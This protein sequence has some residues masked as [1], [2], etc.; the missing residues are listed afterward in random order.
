[1][2]PSDPVIR[3]T[4]SDVKNSLSAYLRKVRAGETVLIMDRKTPIASLVP[5]VQSLDNDTEAERL[6]R[7]VAAGTVQRAAR[8]PSPAQEPVAVAID[9]LG[10]VLAERRSGR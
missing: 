3:A 7:L 9:V 1:L 10:A 4:I 5:I 8:E 6:T 2:I